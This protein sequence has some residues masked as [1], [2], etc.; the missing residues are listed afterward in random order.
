MKVK[1]R[2]TGF[3]AQQIME[4]WQETPAYM[5]AAQKTKTDIREPHGDDTKVEHP[6]RT[7]TEHPDT[8]GQ[9]TPHPILTAARR[10]NMGAAAKSRMLAMPRNDLQP[11]P[12]QQKSRH[13]AGFF[14]YPLFP[15][16]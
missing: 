5:M 10:R 1:G 13:W 12:R 6:I 3:Q 2:R 4:A 16:I 9:S 7:I 11:G 8:Q 15:A 14:S